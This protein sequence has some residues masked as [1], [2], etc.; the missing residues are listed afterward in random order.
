MRAAEARGREPVDGARIVALEIMA[1][2][3]EVQPTPA[4][5]R[6]MATGQQAVDGFR[7]RGF[8]NTFFDGDK[9]E[10]TLTSPEFEISHNHL[11]FLI[12]GGNHAG[13][14]CLNLLV[15]GKAVRTATGRNENR[16][17]WATFDVRELAG[18]QARFEIV[19]QERGGWGNI[20]VDHL[21]FSN[22]AVPRP[23]GGRIAAAA[24]KYKIDPSDLSK[25]VAYLQGTALKSPGDPFH[26][27]AL[28]ATRP[29]R[30]TTEAMQGF[31]RDQ[32]AAEYRGIRSDS[33]T[34]RNV[35]YSDANPITLGSPY[36]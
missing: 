9:S 8:V 3:L 28:L 17:D 30:L 32:L 36:E 11:S 27:W 10:G 7:G 2:L 25:W 16:M 19:D 23:V 1:Q 20:G 18:K 12:G 31:V 13:K 4:K 33:T 29:G 21:L 34:N 5:A 24:R 26:L 6:G 14:T 35:R 22:S 15:D